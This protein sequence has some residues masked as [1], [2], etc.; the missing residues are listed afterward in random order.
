MT[1]SQES[2]QKT[3]VDPQ[4]IPAFLDHMLWGKPIMRTLK[5][6]Y[7]EAQVERNRAPEPAANNYMPAM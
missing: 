7:G 6:P 3:E 1:K 2:K 4:E 5:Q